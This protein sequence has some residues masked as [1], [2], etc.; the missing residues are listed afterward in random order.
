MN[1]FECP[2]CKLNYPDDP[3]L[4]GQS[5]TCQHCGQTIEIPLARV[6]DLLPAD[7]S[8]LAEAELVEALKANVVPQARTLFHFS[9]LDVRL[10]DTK[11]RRLDPF[12]VDGISGPPL[13]P[14]YARAIRNG[15]IGFV[16]ASGKGYLCDDTTD[17]PLG[18]PEGMPAKS[19]SAIPL[20]LRG[21]VIGT[22]S[23][24]RNEPAAFSGDDLK[25]CAL[26]ARDLAAA[27]YRIDARFRQG[28]APEA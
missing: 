16:A 3:V 7:V 26:F 25:L 2:H 5:T 9:S 19:F 23:I 14:V 13:E 22:F 1:R 12:V 21:E 8:H 11:T 15:I 18:V 17:D 6:V 27:L 24:G 28:E 4:A 20:L 10:L